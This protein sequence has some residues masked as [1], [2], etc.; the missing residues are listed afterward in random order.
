MKMR[1]ILVA[2]FIALTTYLI[3][4]HDP[5]NQQKMRTQKNGN[6]FH[7]PNAKG[8]WQYIYP[9][10]NK[11]YI[12]AIQYNIKPEG[13]SPV[14]KNTVIYYGK[15]TGKRYVLYWKEHLFMH[16]VNDNF[17]YEDYNNDGVKDLLLFTTTGSRG[18]NEHYNLYL[19]NPKTKMLSKVS[20]F[21]EI[22]N[23]TYHQKHKVILGYGYAGRNSYTVYRINNKKI[24]QV[25]QSF[26]DADTLD[27]DK[28][29]AQILK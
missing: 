1:L 8:K 7:Q 24:V 26:E 18:S 13:S 10:A 17:K 28:K 21:E 27:L 6:V 9:F 20:G 5:I 12:L 11:N 25:G 2:I 3:A 14:A 4:A 19:I 16:V 15:R 23:P 22:T 29:I